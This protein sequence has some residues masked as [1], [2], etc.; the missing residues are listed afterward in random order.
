MTRIEPYVIKAIKERIVFYNLE[1]ANLKLK[2]QMSKSFA[3]R[4]ERLKNNMHRL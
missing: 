3:E 2:N 1:D 4:K